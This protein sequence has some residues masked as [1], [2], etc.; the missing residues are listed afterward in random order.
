MTKGK[1]KIKA[2]LLYWEYI[3]KPKCLTQFKTTKPA[4]KSG[5]N[6]A[7]IYVLAPTAHVNFAPN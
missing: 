2:C 7:S 1:C 6:A 3:N 5:Q 4:L